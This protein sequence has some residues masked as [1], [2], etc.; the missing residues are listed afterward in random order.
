MRG[1]VLG[2]VLC[3]SY[4]AIDEFCLSL[5]WLERGLARATQYGYAVDL[6]VFARWLIQDAHKMLLNVSRD[7][8]H[9]YLAQSQVKPATQRRRMAVLRSFYAWSLREG[10]IAEDP[11]LLMLRPKITRRRPLPLSVQQVD[12][13][14]CAPRVDQPLG[15][16]D[17]ALLELL[18]GSGM[19]VSEATGLSV[20]G[21]DFERR[22]IQIMGKGS[23]ERIVL[24]GEEAAFWLDR[25]LRTARPAIAMRRADRRLFITRC[26]DG[27]TRQFVWCG[28]VRISVF[29]A[30]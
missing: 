18:Y 9:R 17:R 11:C 12:A 28:G 6:R 19:R 7:D 15:L 14:L 16:R 3:A 27:I 5:L 29:K 25:Y 30:G 23:V 10:R 2:A 1:A 26:G 8:I 22:G 13:L 21:L 20:F 24:F 4:K